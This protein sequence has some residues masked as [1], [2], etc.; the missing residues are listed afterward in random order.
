MES[1]ITSSPHAGN[2]DFHTVLDPFLQSPG[3][4]FSEVLSAEDIEQAFARR[5]ALFGL[6]DDEI[7]STPIVLWAFLAQVLRDGKGA[8][9]AAAVADIAT[10]HLQTNRPVPCGDTGDYCRAR[11]KLDLGALQTLT[12]QA[13]RRMEDEAKD[14]WRWHGRCAKLVDGFT[15][16]MP[17]TPDNRKRSVNTSF[18]FFAG[19]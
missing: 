8:A 3:L 7:F 12:R 11:A 10:H 2:T 17:D 6:R 14:A 16:T 19:R 4:G 5:G 9:C 13:A 18:C 1:K 15:F